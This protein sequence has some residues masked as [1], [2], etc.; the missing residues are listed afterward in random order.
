MIA[1]LWKIFEKAGQPGWA[2]I[3]SFYN[4]YILL[5]IVDR[6]VWWI[7]LVFIPVVNVVVSIILT[8]ELVRAFGKDGSFG[9]LAIFL[10]F[11]AYPILGFGD[12][13]YVGPSKLF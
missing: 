4:L 9:I 5:K 7:V 6:P 13:R 1:S 3:I 11:I 10:P 8:L 2:A 12:A